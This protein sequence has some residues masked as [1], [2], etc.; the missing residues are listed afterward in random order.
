MSDDFRITRHVEVADQ[1]ARAMKRISLAGLVFGSFILVNVLYPYSKDFDESRDRRA[2]VTQIKSEVARTTASLREVRELSGVVTETMDTIQRAPWQSHK[3]DLIATY[4]DMRDR[5][6]GTRADYQSHADATIEK[7]A[8]DIRGAISP[9]R[10]KLESTPE[11]KRAVPEIDAKQEA[12]TDSIN[13]WEKSNIGTRW[14]GTIQGKEA[15]LSDVNENV[16]GH[17]ADMATQVTS[18]IDRFSAA[19]RNSEKQLENDLA[20]QEQEAREAAAKLKELEDKMQSVL[21]AW[22]RGLINIEQMVQIFPIIVFGI[23][24]YLLYSGISLTRH[25][26]IVAQAR[27][28]SPEE[29]QDP[30]YSAPWTLVYRGRVG[31][32]TT[33]ILYTSVVVVSWIF[34]REGGDI[35]IEWINT[36]HEPAVSKA[37]YKPAIN[38]IS[39]LL[40]VGLGYVIWRTLK[41]QI[42]PQ[43]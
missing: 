37:I 13:D 38:G 19:V 14:Y 22:V 12:L 33:I 17:V 16:E 40:F 8:G 25:H 27:Q 11:L 26:E 10:T 31:T 39:A 20:R 3:N 18:S 35:L 15:A 9:L 24:V 32:A 1:T 7:I 34:V 41:S 28:W 43:R 23:A 42:R 29:R 21:P 36:G 5:G 4:A 30:L 6:V 2:S